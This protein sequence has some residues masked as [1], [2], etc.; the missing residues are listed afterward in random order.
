MEVC[1]QWCVQKIQTFFF[2]SAPPKSDPKLKRLYPLNPL[3]FNISQKYFGWLTKMLLLFYIE[4]LTKPFQLK[5]N[6][7]WALV[8]GLISI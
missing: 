2:L 3:Y 5:Y 7:F 6:H 4:R 8:E 1:E